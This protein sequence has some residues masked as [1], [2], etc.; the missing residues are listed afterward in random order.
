MSTKVTLGRSCWTSFVVDSV[1]RSAPERV[2]VAVSAFRQVAPGMPPLWHDAGLG[3]APTQSDGR[4]HRR[5]VGFAQYFSL[6]P[7][8]AWAELIRYFGLRSPEQVVEQRRSLWHAHVEVEDVADLSTFDRWVACGLDPM[9]AVSDDHA[10]CQ[11]VAQGLVEQGYRGVLAPSAALPEAINIT[12]FGGRYEQEAIADPRTLARRD[13]RWLR[14]AVA[15][16]GAHPPQVLV[17]RTRYRGQPHG[18]YEDWASP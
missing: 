5:G 12:V 8:G 1:N 6:S 16:E 18:G 7:A 13:D 17:T 10:G 3:G 11:R 9:D 2:P 15:A 4:W 14:V